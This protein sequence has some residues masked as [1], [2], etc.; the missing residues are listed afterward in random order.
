MK[1]LV[2]VLSL[3]LFNSAFA[4]DAVQ[5]KVKAISY[6][7]YHNAGS[8]TFRIYEYLFNF[9][10]LK[11]QPAVEASMEIRY[12]LNSL[13]ECHTYGLALSTAISNNQ[14][15]A[16]LKLLSGLMTQACTTSF[17]HFD[18]LA[19]SKIANVVE[20]MGYLKSRKDFRSRSEDDTSSEHVITFE[21]EINL[22]KKSVEELNQLLKTN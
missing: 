4:E 18:E 19:D 20:F 12:A 13:T 6:S 2:F 10:A 8:D 5:N 7:I 14:S 21:E 1:S 15:P 17:R 22:L 16:P 3:S 9:L 11:G